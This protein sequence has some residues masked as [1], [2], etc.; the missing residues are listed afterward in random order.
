MAYLCARL[1]KP[2]LTELYGRAGFR[3]LQYGHTYLGRSG[4]RYVDQDGMIA[5]V[6]SQQLFEAIMVQPEP[7]DIGE[8]NW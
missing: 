3:R 8:G 1:D 4:R 2:G 5:P 7:F 6:L